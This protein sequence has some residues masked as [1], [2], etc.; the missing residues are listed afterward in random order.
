MGMFHGFSM[1]F[2]WIFHGHLGV[3]HQKLSLVPR[4]ASEHRGLIRLLRLDQEVTDLR[5]RGPRVFSH[6]IH[7]GSITGGPTNHG[8]TSKEKGNKGKF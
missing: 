5:R 8:K 1:D 3:F 2:P 7:G 6:G 4:L